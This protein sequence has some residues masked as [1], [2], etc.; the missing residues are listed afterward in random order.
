PPPVPEDDPP[1][2]EDEAPPAPPCEPVVAPAPAP[3]SPPAPLERVPESPHEAAKASVATATATMAGSF[4]WRAML[5]TLSRT[6][7]ERSPAGGPARCGAVGSRERC[8]L[9]PSQT[10]SFLGRPPPAS[11]RSSR[12]APGARAGGTEGI[13][14]PRARCGLQGAEHC[15]ANSCQCE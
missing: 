5:F 6:S 4:S 2:P 11:E 12:S 9:I 1:P 13:R 8:R 7:V 15:A 14:R 10:F 3:A